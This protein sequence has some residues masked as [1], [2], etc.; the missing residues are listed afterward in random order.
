VE[1]VSKKI[2]GAIQDYR[3]IKKQQDRRENWVEQM[4]MAQ[5]AAQNTTKTK[6]WKRLK[7]M[8]QS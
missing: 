6:L 2:K 3:T 1:E 8:E 5:A 7:Q 4:I